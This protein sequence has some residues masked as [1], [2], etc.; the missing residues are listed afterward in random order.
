[1]FSFCISGSW[2]SY[3]VVFVLI[4]LCTFKKKYRIRAGN[5]NRLKKVALIT[6]K[7]HPSGNSHRHLQRQARRTAIKPETVNLVLTPE[8]LHRLRSTDHHHINESWRSFKLCTWS[9]PSTFRF[10]LTPFC[11]IYWRKRTK[12]PRSEKIF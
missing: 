12:Q 2:L 7:C 6:D 4:T 11:S 1:M 3:K 10:S 8:L 5:D 9:F